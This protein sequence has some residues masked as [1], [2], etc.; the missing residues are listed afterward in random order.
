MEYQ[1]REQTINYVLVLC[2]HQYKS[3]DCIIKFWFPS[4]DQ[5][6]TSEISISIHVNKCLKAINNNNFQND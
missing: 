6:D 2:L 4:V 3:L 5:I 1:I